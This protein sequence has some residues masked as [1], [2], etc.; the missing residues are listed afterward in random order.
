VQRGEDDA[1]RLEIVMD[2]ELTEGDQVDVSI[3]ANR[4]V[5][6]VVLFKTAARVAVVFP[7]MQTPEVIVA[8]GERLRLPTATAKLSTP[9]DTSHEA[10]VVFAFLEEGDFQRFKPPEGALSDEVAAQYLTE[11]PQRLDELPHRRWATRTIN[12]VITPRAVEPR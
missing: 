6:L 12:Y 10:L 9:G 2:P 3:G 8:A 5:Y 11:L 1:I 4:R 7:N